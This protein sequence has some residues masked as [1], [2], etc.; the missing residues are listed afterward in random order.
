MSLLEDK[1]R[2]FREMWEGLSPGE[3]A[4]RQVQT[5]FRSTSSQEP[6]RGASIMKDAL[7]E[8]KRIGGRV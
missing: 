8:G 6:P 7:Q 2:L 3:E 5:F 4:C 1:V